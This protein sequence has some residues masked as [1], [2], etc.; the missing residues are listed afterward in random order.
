MN[1]H[2]YEH[3]DKSKDIDPYTGQPKS[4]DGS[5][6]LKFWDL[7]RYMFHGPIKFETKVFVFKI[8]GPGNNS[9]KDDYAKLKIKRCKL[10]L[11]KQKELDLL[12]DYGILTRESVTKIKREDK[13][14]IGRPLIEM[15][16]IKFNM[17]YTWDLPL[18][19]IDFDHYVQLH[20][21]R[22]SI[23]RKGK[24]LRDIFAAFRATGLG[25][26]LNLT[27]SSA[28]IQVEWHRYLNWYI[29][30]YNLFMAPPEEFWTTQPKTI[31]T[32][33]YLL[34]SYTFTMELADVCLA[35]N[36][37]SV[38]VG[39]GPP[40]PRG[41][42]TV[43]ANVFNLY[44]ASKYPRLSFEP[45]QMQTFSIDLKQT[46]LHFC[47][48]RTLR[49]VNDTTK[50]KASIPIIEINELG[51]KTFTNTDIPILVVCKNGKLFW[52]VH[53]RDLVIELTHCLG[54]TPE[55]ESSIHVVKKENNSNNTLSNNDN[56]EEKIKK[57][58]KK[59]SKQKDP[60]KD[61]TSK[62][63]TNK[64]DKKN[65]KDNALEAKK[66]LTVKTRKLNVSNGEGNYN[67]ESLLD[68]L[69]QREERSD[70]L[71]S[72]TPTSGGRKSPSLSISSND[73]RY[74]RRRL[75]S[76]SSSTNSF[77]QSSFRKARSDSFPW[78]KASSS[79]DGTDGKPANYIIDYKV[80]LQQ[81]QVYFQ[82]ERTKAGM[83]VASPNVTLT[84][85]HLFEQMNGE[86]DDKI[87]D[88]DEKERMDELYTETGKLDCYIA[89]A[90]IASDQEEP[91]L[92]H[93][94]ATPK[95]N[96]NNSNNFDHA[97]F[98][99]R[100]SSS[101]SIYN[102]T[103]SSPSLEIAQRSFTNF[104][105]HVYIRMA[106]INLTTNSPE[107][108]QIIDVVRNVLLAPPKSYTDGIDNDKDN[109][110]DDLN[111]SSHSNDDDEVVGRT[112]NTSSNSEISDD[113]EDIDDT[114]NDD[115][116]TIQE[117][118]D[119]LIRREAPN[120]NNNNNDTSSTNDGILSELSYSFEGIGWHLQPLNE[121]PPMEIGIKGINGKHTF[122]EDTSTAVNIAIKTLYIVDMKPCALAAINFEDSTMVLKPF[123][124]DRKQQSEQF[125]EIICETAPIA[126]T[127][128]KKRKKEFEVKVYNRLEVSI[129][130]GS[131]YNLCIQL[132]A[133]IAN[134]L[135]NFFF[136]EVESNIESTDMD[137]TALL[138]GE[139]TAARNS[140]N[141][142]KKKAISNDIDILE[143]E[144]DTD[145]V[146]AADDDYIY[147]KRV[148]MGEISLKISLQGYPIVKLDG[149]Q[150]KVG[151]YSRTS[152]LSTWSNLA[153]SIV[154]HIRKNVLGRGG[155]VAYKTIT[156]QSTSISD[157]STI[158]NNN[159]NLDDDE[160][161]LLS[162]I[163][164]KK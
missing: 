134:S 10:Y 66:T 64:K 39:V 65:S 69:S 28:T 74:G 27:T 16:G 12:G 130:P 8:Y 9:S 23:L 127:E 132:T 145:A 37:D 55:E 143:V 34:R 124:L 7:Y 75:S 144:E 107:F 95:G 153:S 3:A 80:D 118:E 136:G 141:K 147:F 85:R 41:D 151:P 142:M 121:D 40:G 125:L 63:R 164:G 97:G 60:E 150:I 108:Y 45:G 70:S 84:G 93:N 33:G 91:W 104:A 128:K 106:V 148:R 44:F 76:G 38:G 14:P 81:L 51:W 4:I 13:E 43:L 120:A 72:E 100:F 57:T 79:E 131:R 19:S 119:L 68:L 158:N 61:T 52:T 129:F 73:S 123:L 102:K 58:N 24:K 159:E 56:D 20:E 31:P 137:D 92:E 87:D 36:D 11:H 126:K 86:K 6:P 5:P 35:V 90:E 48:E 140:S 161:A 133:R 149:F 152:R 30:V 29:K 160:A 46:R 156:F 109:L 78:K 99:R 94:G 112:G 21:Q 122:Y 83:L 138:F 110:S 77:G 67:E 154:A 32:I 26:D 96:N 157:N 105:P 89:P 54:T 17:V 98:E 103:I 59:T 15:E 117:I 155:E 62:K 146:T 88:E 162:L 163:G 101:T 116:P 22:V 71:M 82:D 49:A 113:D 47:P 115:V 50:I 135:S 111:T 114:D 1:T 139:A 2:N 53:N 25:M 18:D 42:S